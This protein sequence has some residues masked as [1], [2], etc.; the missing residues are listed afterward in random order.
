EAV[1][2]RCLVYRQILLRVLELLQE[3]VFKNIDFVQVAG[4]PDE[5][6]LI[7]DI[8]DFE[9]V[10]LSELALDAQRVVDAVRRPQVWVEPGD[11]P[12]ES[13]VGLVDDRLV[14]SSGESERRS[15]QRIG[16]NVRERGEGRQCALSRYQGS[17]ANRLASVRAKVLSKELS[18]FVI[19]NHSVGA[20]ND[21]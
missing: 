8:T 4:A 1:H 18:P 20:A 11:G 16:D 2:A 5:M 10:V 14:G 6:G 7:A 15:R 21:S 9:H 3:A 17:R 13:L 19:N 12:G